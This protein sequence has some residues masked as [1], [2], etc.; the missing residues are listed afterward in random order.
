MFFSIGGIQPRTVRLEKQSRACPV[1]SHFNVYLERTDRYIS[2][3]FIPIIPVKRGTPY[4]ICENCR[5]ILDNG[6]SVHGRGA[7]E[8]DIHCCSACWKTLDPKFSYCPYC[9][10]NI[11]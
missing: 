8:N 9:G 1:C 7:G 4:V 10:K 11:I 2:L 3:F 5:T 6:F